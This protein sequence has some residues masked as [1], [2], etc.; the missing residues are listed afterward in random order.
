[1]ARAALKESAEEL[2]ALED[3]HDAHKQEMWEAAY[4]DFSLYATPAAI[5]K[6]LAEVTFLR[7]KLVDQ[8]GVAD[9]TLDEVLASM[10]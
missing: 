3:N 4:E 10:D 7:Q 5:L 9:E 1:M 2:I 6:L 8:L